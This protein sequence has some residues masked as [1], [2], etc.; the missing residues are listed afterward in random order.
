[1]KARIATSVLL[2]V[3]VLLGTSACNFFVPQS[4]TESYTA[5][6]GVDAQ[7]GDLAI[8]N[9]LLITSDGQS[10]NLVVTVVSDATDSETLNIQIDAG[11]SQMTKTLQVPG[12]KTVRVPGNTATVIAGAG[13]QELTF[14]NLNVV[15][16]S[17]APVYFQYGDAEGAS[18]L[19]PVLNT[20][21][22]QYSNLAPTPTPTPI[23]V[24]ESTPTPEP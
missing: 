24:P 13:T 7:V 22:A 20:S 21:M 5:S 23:T 16:G 17:L 1:M 4:T 11:S 10:A 19:V 12:K 3:G 18:V 9:A 8:R 6:D 14:D 2:A 15:V